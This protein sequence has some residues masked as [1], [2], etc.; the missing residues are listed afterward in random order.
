M[1]APGLTLPRLRR[2]QPGAGMA[3]VPAGRLLP[4]LALP[5]SG[6]PPTVLSAVWCPQR[7]GSL[8]PAWLLL[9]TRVQEAP[10]STE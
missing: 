5:V 7:L 2:P 3:E 9:S 10:W 1:G 8:T 6:C 4:L